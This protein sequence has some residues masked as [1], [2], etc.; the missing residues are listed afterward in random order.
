MD[1]ISNHNPALDALRRQLA[2]SV[3]R[4][5]KSGE[6]TG[7]SARRAGQ[8]AARAKG[9]ESILQRRISAIDRRSLEG[10]AHA[11]YAFVESVLVAEFGEALLSDPGLGKMLVEISDSIRED[12]QLRDQLDDLLALLCHK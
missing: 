12:P 10:K 4:L 5:R 7:S 11:T 6:S 2:E 1:P 8:P 3:K 9:L